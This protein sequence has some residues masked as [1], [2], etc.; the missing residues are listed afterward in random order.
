[1]DALHRQGVTVT[2]TDT[3]IDTTTSAVRII[4][5]NAGHPGTRDD[6]IVIRVHASALDSD[7]D[8]DSTVAPTAVAD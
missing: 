6:V 7:D 5:A 3:A 1:M 8:L 2:S 4:P